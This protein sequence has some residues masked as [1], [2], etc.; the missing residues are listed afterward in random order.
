MLIL[1]WQGLVPQRKKKNK[2]LVYH[3]E[4]LG[5][6]LLLFIIRQSEI[7]DTRLANMTNTRVCFI[8]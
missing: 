1:A 5:L 2:N 6:L 3:L 7:I 8:F 4:F